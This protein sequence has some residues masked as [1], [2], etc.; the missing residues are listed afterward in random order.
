MSVQGDITPSTSSKLRTRS[1]PSIV[2]VDTSDTQIVNSNPNR[3][4]VII[5]N[6]G[7]NE[8]HIDIDNSVSTSSG[9]RLAAGGIMSITKAFDGELV[10][11]HLIGIATGASSSVRVFEII[12]DVKV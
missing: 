1:V 4:E 6:N 9:L 5:A 11:R 10:T 3:V 12:Q 2:T 8:I 7:S